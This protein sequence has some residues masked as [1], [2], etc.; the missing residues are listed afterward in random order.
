MTELT[1]SERTC[2]FPK[3]PGPAG[4]VHACQLCPHSPTYW[5]GSADGGS[6]DAQR[7]CRWTS[8]TKAGATP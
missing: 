6:T 3:R 2:D 8:P 1:P 4:H 7:A 5:R